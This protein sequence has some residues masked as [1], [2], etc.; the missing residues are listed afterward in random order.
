M[1]IPITH[2]I[3]H[4]NHS[5]RTTVYIFDICNEQIRLPHS[6]FSSSSQ[7]AIWT[8]RSNIS[9]YIYTKTQLTVTSTSSVIT[10]YV[11]ETYMPTK[12]G[13]YAKYLMSKYGNE[14]AYMCHIWSMCIN[15]YV[16]YKV[17]DIHIH[18][19]MM[20]ANERWWLLKAEFGKLNQPKSKRCHLQPTSASHYT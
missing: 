2:D 8:Y 7:Y 10:K 13:T 3:T 20:F 1:H 18:R 12:L 5:T 19:Q 4:I 16:L 17:V 11:W 15:N 14:H 9:A 6:Q